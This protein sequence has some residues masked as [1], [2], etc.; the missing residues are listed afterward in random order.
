MSD[1]INQTALTLRCGDCGAPMVRR[2]GRGRRFFGCSRFPEC[3]GSLSAHQVS[4]LPMGVPG[5]ELTR[6]ARGWAHA[7]FDELWRSGGMRRLEAYAW[8][9]RAMGL[10][11]EE[12]H[13]GRF[14]IEQC[15]RLVVR[16]KPLVEAIRKG[17][18][19]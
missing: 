3:R 6:A 18:A 2:I 8:M 15:V 9:Q 19:A 14:S 4:G 16:I 11:E 7:H 12:A 17:R 1:Q 5:D 13:I 10:S